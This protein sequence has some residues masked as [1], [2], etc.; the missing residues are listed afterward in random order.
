MKK[1]GFEPI[2][3]GVTILNTFID[4]DSQRDS[5][6][7]YA[8]GNGYTVKDDCAYDGDRL[9]ISLYDY[10]VEESQR[11]TQEFWD[12]LHS[13]KESTYI[14]YYVVTGSLGLWDGR[15]S[16]ICETFDNLYDALSKCSSDAYDIV[17]KYEDK[18]LKFENHHHDGTNYFEVYNLSFDDYDKVRYWDDKD[19]NVFDYIKKH[20]KPIS[21]EMIGQ[22]A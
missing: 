18:A 19:G 6:V 5:L 16:G 2:R 11:D 20:A 17:V 10:A 12:G 15:H 9:V 3:N 13:A 7:D 21:W 14:D 8:L 4:E 1:R 22:P